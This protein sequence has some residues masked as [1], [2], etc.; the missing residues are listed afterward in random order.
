M[1]KLFAIYQQLADAAAFDATT[2]LSQVG[3]RL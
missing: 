3:G 1:A 2:E